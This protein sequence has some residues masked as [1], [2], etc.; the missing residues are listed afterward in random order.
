MITAHIIGTAAER[1]IV[2]GRIEAKTLSSDT[3]HDF[4]AHPASESRS[5]DSIE[6]IQNRPVRLEAAIDFLARPPSHFALDAELVL[7][8]NVTAE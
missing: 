7:K 8:K 2:I 6:V 5:P 1:A 4:G 3:T